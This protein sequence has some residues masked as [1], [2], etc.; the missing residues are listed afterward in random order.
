MLRLFSFLLLIVFVAMSPSNARAS[1]GPL[2]HLSSDRLSAD[3]SGILLV[4]DEQKEKPAA[5][6]QKEKAGGDQPL[7]RRGGPGALPPPQSG[8]RTLETGPGLS[9]PKK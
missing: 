3:H 4:L 2:T 1:Q 5:E 7:K 6:D 8:N 9:P